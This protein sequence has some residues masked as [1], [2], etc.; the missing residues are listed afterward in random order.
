MI[1]SLVNS[2]YLSDKETIKLIFS[3]QSMLWDCLTHSVIECDV[4]H[5][6]VTASTVV[7]PDTL[8]NNLKQFHDDPEYEL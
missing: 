3:E 6:Y 7:P 4:V 8:D 5:S 2:L 1:R